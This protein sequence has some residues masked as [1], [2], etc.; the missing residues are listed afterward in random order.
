MKKCSILLLIAA[1]LVWTGCAHYP[2][3]AK[4]SQID[5]TRGYRFANLVSPDNSDSLFVILAFSGGGTRAAALSYGVLQQLKRSPA[6]TWEGQSR[7]LLEEVDVIS[8]VSGG[9]FTAAYFGLHGEGIFDDFKSRFLYVDVEG[10][11]KSRLFSPINWFRL[12]S[13]DFDRIDMAAEYYDEKI[14]GHST[15]GTLL[16]RKRRPFLIIN[17]TDMTLGDRFEFSQDQFDPICSNLTSYPLARAVAAS[18]AFPVLLSPITINNYAGSCNFQ[19]PPWV[20]NALEDRAITS[21]RYQ[22]ASHLRA[23]EDASQRPYLHLMDGGI[24]DNIGLRGP[25]QAITT[26]DSPWSLLAMVNRGKI[27]KV[28]VIVV[29]AK[30]EPDSNL[31]RKK[32]AP[33]LKEVLMSV[34]TTP[35]DNYS[36]DTVALLADTVRSWQKDEQVRQACQTLLTAACPDARMPGGP[37]PSVDFYPIVISFDSL[38]DPAQRNFFKNLPTSFTLPA[39]T[40]DRLIDVGGRLLAKSKEFQALLHDLR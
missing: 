27:R 13:F 26:T 39:S 20:A 29:N 21:R 34:A 40:V 23:Y 38:A 1:V 33:N 16:E 24:A 6:F 3:N 22:Q 32:S 8:S 36:F 37:L 35:M 28:V 14:F 9:S 17:A 7:T 12:M 19:E 5:S 2:K 4:L 11:L 30:T 10:A 31:D 18:S 15:F 25:L